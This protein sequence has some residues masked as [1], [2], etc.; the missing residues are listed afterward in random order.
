M[1]SVNDGSTRW[2]VHSATP[3]VSSA[4]PLVGN[5][6]TEGPAN[7]TS[8]ASPVTNS[9]IEMPTYVAVTIARSSGRPR[10]SAANVPSGMPTMT[11]TARAAS[12][13][14]AELRRREATIVA[15]GCFIASDTPQSPVTTPVIQL[16]YCAGRGRSRPISRSKVRT[17]S[18][19]A[20]SPR[21][22]V[23]A[24]PGNT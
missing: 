21:M 14:N 10:R 18:G 16:P 9:G 1:V 3:L 5:Q 4:Y 11:T 23:A 2:R 6:P 13:R 20:Y 19:V 22:S 12:A 24:L 15:T 8:N 17:A 7:T